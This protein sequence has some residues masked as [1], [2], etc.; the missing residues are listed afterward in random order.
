MNLDGWIFLGF[1]LLCMLLMFV[2]YL[3][4]RRLKK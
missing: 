4:G 1:M 2:L 3:T